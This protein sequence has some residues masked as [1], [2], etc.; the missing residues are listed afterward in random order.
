MSDNAIRDALRAAALAVAEERCDMVMDAD[1]DACTA[2]PV[3]T[4]RDQTAAAVAAFLRRVAE[5]RMQEGE[6][7]KT[8]WCIDT[9]A[10]VERAAQEAMP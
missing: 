8:I 10:A 7:D 2:G 1:R 9:A 5:L 4:C 6:N 3:C